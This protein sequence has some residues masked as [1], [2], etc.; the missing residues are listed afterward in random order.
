MTHETETGF[1]SGL[2][3]QIE[4]KQGTDEPDAQACELSVPFDEPD[5]AE[6]LLLI[7]DESAA[8]EVASV[9]AELEGA[10]ERERQ[11]QSALEHQVEAYE[12]E[13]AAD[14]DLAVRE[15]EFE[16]RA[17]RLESARA[18]LEEQ[19][20][21]LRIQRDQVERERAEVHASRTELVAEEARITQ[22]A[23]HID[24]R[25]NELRSEDQERAQAGA[26]LAQQLA[27]IAERERELK[28]E[29][30]AL[31]AR[32]QEG[33]ARIAA[34]ERGVRELD[35]AALR[36]ERVVADRELAVQGVTGELARERVRLQE[37]AEA[38]A[39]REAAL[40]RTGDARAQML[41]N[42]EA[43]LA[44]W[45]KRLREQSERMNRERA[46]HGH[47]SQEAFAL[48]AELEQREEQVGRRETQL[49]DAEAAFSTR[50]EELAQAEEDLRLREARLGADLELREDRLD[51]RERLLAE[52]ERL[53]GDRD[54]ELT[55]YV[56]ELQGHFSE[57]SVA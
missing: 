53:I 31:D 41:V 14:R 15:A 36:R 28:R 46:G 54:R 42:G 9:Q 27:A 32:R 49:L 5:R 18:E 22:L 24:S 8:P 1:G 23:T 45:E 50:R 4:R 25:S 30:A 29:R 40:E 12:R 7:E 48:L 13:L 35:V 17:A 52:R 20:V 55:A 26:H 57:R 56:G 34:R 43:A 3:A 21:V 6:P 37:R 38:L 44:A 10:L 39:T 2:R 11:L 16:Q 19:Q 51:D 33:E 47:A